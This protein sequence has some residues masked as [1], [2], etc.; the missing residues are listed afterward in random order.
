VTYVP[1]ATA[2]PI[3]TSTAFPTI[4]A[5]GTRTGIAGV[6][7][8]IRAILERDAVAL[9]ALMPLQEVGCTNKVDAPGGPPPCPETETGYGP[10]GTR[11]KAFPSGS[12]SSG[13]S[14]DIAPLASV[15]TQGH[16]LFAVVQLRRSTPLY[17]DPGLLA[18]YSVILEAN[19][20]SSSGA[21]IVLINGNDVIHV[22]AA[23]GDR[24]EQILGLPSYQNGPVLILR[25]PAYRDP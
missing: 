20:A 17:D 7:A 22:S 16:H 14:S 5:R 24:P 23:C 6:D 13:W 4:E 25:G 19:A 12:C 2:T 1:P 15:L 10:D 11:V 3:A 21:Y 18:E 9:T 8:V